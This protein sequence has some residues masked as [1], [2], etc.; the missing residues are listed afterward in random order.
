MKKFL[1]TVALASILITSLASC[2]HVHNFDE[3]EAVKA[4]TCTE[5]G[6]KERYC[7]C[8]EKQTTSIITKEHNYV[9]GICT[10]CGHSNVV[11]SPDEDNG[12]NDSD[13]TPSS[14]EEEKYNEALA[15]LESAEYAAAKKLFKELGDYKDAKVYLTRF[16]NVTT[17]VSEDEKHLVITYSDKN[18][19]VESTY[20]DGK[21]SGKYT[22]SYDDN[23]KILK[24][25]GIGSDGSIE[26]ITYTYDQRGDLIRVVFAS[27]NG[28]NSTED[29]TY[30]YDGNN[31]LIKKV[32]VDS[33]YNR[34][35]SDY[36]YNENGNLIK[37]IYTSHDGYVSTRNYIYNT[38]GKLSEITFIDE[39]NASTSFYDESG[40]LVKTVGTFYG[41]KFTYYY[42]KNGNRVRM[43]D[44]DAAGNETISEYTYDYTYDENGNL[45]KMVHINKSGSYLEVNYKLV[46]IPYDISQN[47]IEIISISGFGS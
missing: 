4:S 43:V 46:Y 5:E 44:T 1:S 32:Y 10:T 37:E 15:L 26:S 20:F 40:N 2:S 21:Y 36:T 12:T 6:T 30:Y 35:I 42:D 33:E 24:G 34:Y 41:S 18:L 47:I 14:P 16:H 8:G 11:V 27:S 45:I 9:S 29:Y 17:S 28:Y 23:G 38:N 39:M 3:W 31:N 22:Y 25:S 19:P 7:S 13:V